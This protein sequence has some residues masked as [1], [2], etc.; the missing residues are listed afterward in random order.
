MKSQSLQIGPTQVL[1]SYPAE[2]QSRIVEDLGAAGGFSG[3][4]FWRIESPAGSMC[5]RCW[6]AEH[7]TTEG[8]EFIHSV[9]WFACQDGV[10]FVP[11]PV[12]TNTQSSYVHA[13]GHL[14]ELSPWMPGRADYLVDPRPEKLRA[15][16]IALA[17]F[18]T[19][20]DSFPL[21]H[22]QP[23]SAPGIVMRRRRVQELLHGDLDDL[24]RSI[25]PGRWPDLE[26]RAT[27]L[28]ELF[29]RAVNQVAT[30]LNRA[31]SASVT[32][33]PCLRDIWADHVLFEGDEVTALVDFGAMRP[34]NVATDIARLLGSMA[35]DD[36]T[37]WADGLEAYAT[38]RPVSDAERLLIDAFDQSNVLM[39]GLNWLDWIYRQQRT[40]ENAGAIPCRLDGQIARLEHLV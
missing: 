4:R 3:A 1:A 16:M 18:H 8:L 10:D 29:S 39:S 17:T 2:F 38:L 5:L 32:L 30:S 9:L 22:C 11:L 23:T 33:Q 19:A 27:R 26:V 20:C 15:A 35:A 21:P 12:E 14:W 36:Q 34:D 6:P 25:T 37:A 7:P 31:A 13:S 24:R 40:F 28:F